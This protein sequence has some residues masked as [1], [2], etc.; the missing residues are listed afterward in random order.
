M[1]YLKWRLSNGTWGNGPEAAIAE[2]GGKAEASSYVDGDG[3]R[4][5][6]LTESADIAGLDD[7]DLTEISEAEAL[8]FSRPFYADAEVLPD[9]RISS[10]PPEPV[11][12]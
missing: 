2:R 7:Y 9:G 3:Y 12:P 6:Y 11:E 5:G 10:P 4:V 8:A 1:T